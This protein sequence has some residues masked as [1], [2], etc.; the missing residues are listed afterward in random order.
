M[1]QFLV[2]NGLPANADAL[3]EFINL[4]ITGDPENGIPANEDA[5]KRL[6]QNGDVVDATPT[7]EV[8][9]EGV[10][11]GDWVDG[12]FKNVTFNSVLAHD[13][14][15]RLGETASRVGFTPP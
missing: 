2:D 12:E 10:T 6:T 4:Q 8:F 7:V 3:E 14:V 11:G 5:F 15:E 1:G 13:H 9:F